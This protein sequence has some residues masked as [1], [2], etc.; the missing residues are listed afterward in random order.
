MPELPTV[1]QTCSNQSFEEAVASEATIYDPSDFTGRPAL[2]IPR[3]RS[4][5]S[6]GHPASQPRAKR[7]AT[8]SRSSSTTYASV[9]E[10]AT[11][12]TISNRQSAIR[13][14]QR[15][16]AYVT[17]LE[18]QVKTLSAEVAKSRDEL[19]V[20]ATASL[21]TGG[22]RSLLPTRQNHV[23]SCA[24]WL[25]FRLCSLM[26]LL[27][28]LRLVPFAVSGA[29]FLSWFCALYCQVLAHKIA[30]TGST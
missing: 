4:H 8:A 27:L 18:E 11:R 6:S 15:Q 2:R 22:L 17:G 26:S 29:K 24:S 7:L 20:E 19:Y 3:L 12:R 30:D 25:L 23:F 1:P 10:G 13:S 28:L 21:A 9:D 16:R 5:S 14:K